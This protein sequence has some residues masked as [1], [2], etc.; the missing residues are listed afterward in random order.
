MPP[1]R[2][3]APWRV[4]FGQ[5]K[6]SLQMIVPAGGAT[7]ATGASTTGGAS[8]APTSAGT[9]GPVALCPPGQFLIS[10]SAGSAHLP[11]ETR[12]CRVT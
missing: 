4:V 2:L 6:Q 8:G 1:W 9:P 7:G 3:Q 10:N 11:A 12:F 5:T